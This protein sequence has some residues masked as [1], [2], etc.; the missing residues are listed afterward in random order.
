MHPAADLQLRQLGG[1]L[2][3]HAL[4]EEHHAA[5]DDVR[6]C[7]LELQQ[8]PVADQVPRRVGAV[9][10]HP[11]QRGQRQELRLTRIAQPRPPPALV[12]RRTPHRRHGRK[13]YAGLRNR[14]VTLTGPDATEGRMFSRYRILR[15]LAAIASAGMLALSGCGNTDSWVD[16]APAA[17]WPAQYADAANSSYTPTA[18]AETLKA[19][20]EPLGQGRLVRLGGARRHRHPLPG[21]QCADRRPAAR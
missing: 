9:G 3:L 1:G 15:R 11:F 13:A 6:V 19:G 2:D 4:A 10:H 16:A 21:R 18:G 20:V 14:R 17:G 12:Q 7:Q 5:G 8:P